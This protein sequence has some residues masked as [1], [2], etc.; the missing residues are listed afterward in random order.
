MPHTK[1]LTT[2]EDPK[3]MDIVNGGR[4]PPE[5]TPDSE[6]MREFADS[7]EDKKRILD[8]FESMEAI[9]LSEAARKL[10]ISKYKAFKMK[11]GDPEFAEE[12]KI[13]FELVADRIEE[14]LLNPKNLTEEKMAGVTARIFLLNGLRPNKYK[15]TKLTIENPRLEQ[16]LESIK[17][18]GQGNNGG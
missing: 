14:E 12:L 16:L 11:R 2:K 9:T 1:F 7:I 8:L 6:K 3:V 10:G 15:G 5:L 4:I 18:A 13:A 17:R